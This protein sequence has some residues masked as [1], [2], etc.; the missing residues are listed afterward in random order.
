MQSTRPENPKISVSPE[1]L[2]SGQSPSDSSHQRDLEERVLAELLLD[3]YEFNQKR[4]PRV[5]TPP[6]STT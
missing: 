3:I 1:K 6:D 5:A 2:P 4:K